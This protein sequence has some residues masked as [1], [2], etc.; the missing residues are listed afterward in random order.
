MGFSLNFMYGTNPTENGTPFSASVN[1]GL[2]RKKEGTSLKSRF[3]CRRQP[4]VS[5]PLSHP[6]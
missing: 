4:E 3:Q 1:C 2:G 6:L 5:P